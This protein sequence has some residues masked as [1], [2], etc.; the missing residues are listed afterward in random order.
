M[1]VMR[2]NGFPM[3]FLRL[4]EA[5]KKRVEACKATAQGAFATQ[6]QIIENIFDFPLDFLERLCYNQIIPKHMYAI[7]HL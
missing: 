5:C 3:R 7:D 2:V 4:C 6:K 1:R